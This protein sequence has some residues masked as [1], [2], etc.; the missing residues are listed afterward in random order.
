M[1]TGTTCQNTHMSDLLEHP[2]T[3]RKSLPTCL[4]LNK[5]HT[6]HSRNAAEP[7]RKITDAFN[8][9]TRTTPV[10]SHGSSGWARDESRRMGSRFSQGGTWTR[11]LGIRLSTFVNCRVLGGW[12]LHGIL[13]KTT[14]SSVATASKRHSG[15][16]AFCIFSF[17][18]ERGGIKQS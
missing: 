13:P 14:T 15:L 10:A 11:L 16:F 3:D 7:V 5:K 6:S 17:Q 9:R 1:T 18:R 12:I 8:I 2:V 4:L